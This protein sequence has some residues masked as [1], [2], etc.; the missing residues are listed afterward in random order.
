MYPETLQT[1][2]LRLFTGI[3][4]CM[5]S[6]N[7]SASTSRERK[8]AAAAH[9]ILQYSRAIRVS[10][11]KDFQ[12]DYGSNDQKSRADRHSSS[13]GIDVIELRV[14]QLYE[15]AEEDDTHPFRRE[16]CTSHNYRVSILLIGGDGRT[17]RR[18]GWGFGTRV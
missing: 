2:R 1:A 4:Q 16:G 8:E 12:S 5:R 7:H 15:V 3:P 18:A 9:Q 17:T 10:Q 6:H 11:P 14:F 13:K